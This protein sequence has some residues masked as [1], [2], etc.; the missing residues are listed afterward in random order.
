[1]SQGQVQLGKQGITENFIVTIK[2]HFNKHDNVKV[3]VLKSARHDREDMKK[4]AEKIIDSLGPYYT[5][6]TLGFS[7]FLKKWRKPQR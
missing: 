7:I 6:K 3:H 1:M 2:H 5:A 4:Y